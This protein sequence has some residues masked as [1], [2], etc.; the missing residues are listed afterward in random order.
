LDPGGTGSFTL[1]AFV[2]LMASYSAAKEGWA[3]R[4]RIA[5]GSRHKGLHSEPMSYY[6]SCG[7]RDALVG[8]LYHVDAV[9]PDNT[10]DAL[11]LLA[12]TL[13]RSESSYSAAVPEVAGG[14]Q[15]ADAAQPEPQQPEAEAAGE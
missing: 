5:V 14:A 2:S 11:Q 9:R 6:S 4:V 12:K 13:G 7:V 1:E 15:A 10:E 8:A 3:R